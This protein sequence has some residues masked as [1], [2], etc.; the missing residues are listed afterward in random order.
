MAEWNWHI[1]LARDVANKIEIEDIGSFVVGSVLPDCPWT[2]CDVYSAGLSSVRNNMHFSRI[3]NGKPFLLADPESFIG[4]YGKKIYHN[5]LY[6]GWYT[7]LVL[8][9]AVNSLWNMLC[10]RSSYNKYFLSRMGSV[11]DMRIDDLINLKWDDLY[12]YVRKECINSVL[13]ML[14]NSVDTLS[15]SCINT[16]MRLTG[17]GKAEI[18]SMLSLINKSIWYEDRNRIELP[19]YRR[20]LYDMIHRSCVEKCSAVFRLVEIG[21]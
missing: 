19:R 21:F 7:H 16:I 3:I 10:D 11:A 9:E 20:D 6:K 13:G 17:I 15:D 18:S 2:K 8:D 1:L 14:P 12:S 4:E 5:D